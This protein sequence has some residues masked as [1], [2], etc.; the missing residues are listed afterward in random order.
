MVSFA[1]VR[2]NAPRTQ[3]RLLK[4]LCD[5][6]IALPLGQDFPIRRLLRLEPVEV[7]HLGGG[8]GGGRAG[9]G[10]NRDGARGLGG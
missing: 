1:Y 7:I 2:G 5:A 3:E 4:P 6:W 9:G 10:V 8:V